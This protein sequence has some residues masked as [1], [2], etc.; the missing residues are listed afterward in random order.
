MS[1]A[2]FTR[3]AELLEAQAFVIKSCYSRDGQWPKGVEMIT[4]AAK[5]DHDEHLAIA[6]QL[7]AV[8]AAEGAAR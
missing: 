4:E 6:A 8:V 3:A 5:A 1:A 2:T 7:R